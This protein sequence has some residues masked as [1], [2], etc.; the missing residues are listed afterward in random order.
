M[1]VLQKLCVFFFRLQ[2]FEKIGGIL[3]NYTFCMIDKRRFIEYFCAMKIKLKKMLV[4]IFGILF[5]YILLGAFMH[6]VIFPI[7]TPDYVQHFH[8]GKT[9]TSKME[10]LHITVLSVANDELKTRLV[11][12]PH[13]KGPI[14]HHHEN[15]DES[16]TV[17]K[18]SLSLEVEGQIKVLEAGESFVVKRGTPHRPFNA[19]DQSVEV[20]CKMAAAFAYCLEHLYGLWDA[21][22]SNATPP[23]ILLH[24]A[25]MGSRFDSYPTTDGPPAGVLKVIKFVLGP[26]AR[27]LGYGV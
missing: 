7:R 9:L 6:L 24:I 27:I 8:S 26:T 17:L 5:A 14:A 11:L 18:G 21:D 23:K 13:A 1:F 4:W 22:S 2:Q 16:F 19:T 12:E 10:G 20:E 3:F 25:P 15:F